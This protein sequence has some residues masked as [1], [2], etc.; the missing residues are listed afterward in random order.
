MSRA[1]AA[2]PPD[3]DRVLDLLRAG[4]LALVV[5]GHTSMGVIGWTDA[6]PQVNTA[7]DFYPWAQWA[8]WGLQIMPLFFVAGGAANARSWR[9]TELAYA[10]WL[11]R[12]VAR[13]MRPVW[14]YLAIMAP[15]SALAT[16]A[17]PEGWAAPL[18][19]LATQ[20]LWFVGVYVVVCALTPVLARLHAWHPLAG[21]VGWL[22]AV[23]L[24]DWLRIGL[25]IG[26]VGLLT[27]V[28]AW[29]FAAQLGLLL[30]D[31]VLRGRRGLGA[32]AAAVAANLVLINAGP[33]PISMVGGSPGERFSNMAPPSLALA[34]H[35]LALAGLAGASRPVLAR[36]AH[37]RRVW[38][39]ATAVNL[40]AMTL[41]LWHLPA[42]ITL[43]AASH[44][45]GL[46]RPVAWTADGPA[47]APG[48]WTWTVL[49][50]VID[51]A[52]V[53]GVVR[54]LWVVEVGRLPGW[55][56]PAR[57]V[58]PTRAAER[59][60]SI[61]A[62]TGAGVIGVGTLMLSATGLAGFPTRVTHFAGVPLNAVVAIALM[63]GGGLLVRAAGSQQHATSQK[64]SPNSNLALP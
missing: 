56:R 14:V 58:P 20:L 52:C 5:L 45:L 37:R 50:V 8:T 29:A 63:V 59:A 62:A 28:L 51:L 54:V 26:P 39:A 10:P 57:S 18:L 31:G 24:V 33:Y 44:A 7:L 47:P 19:G 9:S 38:W 34:L 25:G 41:Y 16:V 35:A 21:P 48:Y 22:V 1:V 49:F 40:T 61:A 17:L 30:D 13:L 43:V 64:V 12:R 2:T 4:A 32:A 3:R 53:I 11:W 60:C 6:G 42:L 15:A 46:D 23:A 55:D 36:L 27:F